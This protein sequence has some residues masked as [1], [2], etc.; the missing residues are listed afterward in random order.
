MIEGR[1]SGGVLVLP[2]RNMAQY[3]TDRIGNAEEL[4][5]YEVLWTR[6]NELG[7]DVPY[8]AVVGVEHDRTDAAVPRIAKMTDG[9]AA[10]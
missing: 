6:W 10:R 3:L 7:G 4:E 9:R 8:L 2:T 1:I 5:S